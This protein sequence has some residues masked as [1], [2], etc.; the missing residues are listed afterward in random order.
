MNLTLEPVARSQAPEAGYRRWFTDFGISERL[1]EHHRPRLFYAEHPGSWFFPD[2]LIRLRFGRRLCQRLELPFEVLQ[3]ERDAFR[4]RGIKRLFLQWRLRRDQPF[5]LLPGPRECRRWRRMVYGAP[6]LEGRSAARVQRQF[7]A[8]LDVLDAA[9]HADALWRLV[10]A[11]QTP[12]V[13]AL[14]GPVDSRRETQA[15]ARQL[16]SFDLDAAHPPLRL[17]LERLA[18]PIRW[19]EFW[20][21]VNGAYAGVD[22]GLLDPWLDRFVLAI[23]DPEK[24]A[25]RLAELIIEE[26]GELPES[27]NVAGFVDGGRYVQV[28]YEPL[29]RRFARR[30]AG[31]VEDFDWSELRSKALEGQSTGPTGTIFYMMLAATGGFMLADAN[32]GRTAFEQRTA[33]CHRRYLGAPYPWIAPSRAYDPRGWGT[34]LDGFH[35]DFDTRVSTILQAG[36]SLFLEK[37]T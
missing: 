13:R 10:S 37:K 4:D 20:R 28:L 11:R 34:Y 12:D 15:W 8:A 30:A 2:D 6:R 1:F 17:G 9:G 32:D 26:G 19:A 35:S 33:R 29:R 36:D 23:D 24:M 22:I 25:R 21:Q 5:V 31:T 16:E 14:L 3:M 27:I 18:E 7:Q